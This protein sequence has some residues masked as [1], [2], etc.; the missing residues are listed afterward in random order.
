MAVWVTAHCFSRYFVAITLVCWIEKR[1]ILILR[2]VFPS[3]PG[4][5]KENQTVHSALIPMS[6][7]TAQ[8]GPVPKKRNPPLI[9]SPRGIN[10]RR[11][12]S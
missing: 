8:M 12:S 5:I 7:K 6:E 2:L 4:L 11:N 9:V 1:S 3:N 10:L